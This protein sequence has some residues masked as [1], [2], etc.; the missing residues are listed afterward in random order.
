MEPYYQDDLTTLYCA[1][2]LA[3]P[4]LWTEG[5]VLVTDPPYGMGYVSNRSKNGP[6]KKIVGDEKVT[7]RD[8]MLNIWHELDDRKPALVF[9]TWKIPRP[10]CRNVIAW[11]KGNDPGTGDL[12]LSWGNSWEEVYVIGYGFEGKRV[13]NHIHVNKY[14]NTA[15]ARPKH[16]TPKPVKL[17]EELL[18]KCPE[19]W[20]I[21]DPFAGSGATLLA[22]RNLGRKSIGVEI[23]PDYCEMIV[24]RIT[25]EA[26]SS[27]L[28]N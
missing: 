14:G 4:E 25:G 12:R 5:E 19:E 16:P 18:E 15:K 28:D 1:D 11:I 10:N 23:D 20:V 8:R 27:T 3:N 21:V 7:T 9:G 13:P 6:S 17:M 26:T 22:A 2:A 24:E